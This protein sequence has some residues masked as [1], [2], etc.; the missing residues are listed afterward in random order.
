MKLHQFSQVILLVLVGLNLAQ[1]K[2]S[3]FKPC[4]IQTFLFIAAEMEQELVNFFSLFIFTT[5]YLYVRCLQGAVIIGSRVAS[6]GPPIDLC[7]C[8]ERQ[9]RVL[10][11][12]K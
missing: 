4:S 9:K 5:L 2:K 1:K 3:L 8:R 12:N 7:N 10:F 11:I 6:Q